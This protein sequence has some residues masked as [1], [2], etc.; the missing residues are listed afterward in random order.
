[1]R[2]F[3]NTSSRGK[4]GKQVA[5]NVSNEDVPKAKAHF[6]VLRTRGEK[7]DGDDYEGKSF[8]FF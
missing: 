5:P 8:L 6:Y 1:M 3:P 2:D 7:S 4:N